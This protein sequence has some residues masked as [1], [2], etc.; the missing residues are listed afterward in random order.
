MKEHNYY[1]ITTYKI[2]ATNY[3]ACVHGRTITIIDLQTKYTFHNI[4]AHHR[5]INK[6]IKYEK[7]TNHI[8]IISRSKDKTIKVWCM[9]D[10]I[11]KYKG[12]TYTCK[13]KVSTNTEEGAIAMYEINEQDFL[14][15]VNDQPKSIQ[16]KNLQKH[17]DIYTLNGHTKEIIALKTYQKNQQPYLA[18]AGDDTTIIIWDLTNRTIQSKLSGHMCAIST[19]EIIR[20]TN[21][22]LYI[23]SGSNDTIKLWDLDTCQAKKTLPVISHTQRIMSIIIKDNFYLFSGHSNGEI[24]LWSE[25]NHRENY[26]PPTQSGCM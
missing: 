3:A 22:K 1:F 26:S 9:K 4:W 11:S 21:N 5:N 12:T 13:Y 6:F 20:N 16:L 2:D 23:A 24:I 8:Y 19:I 18:S 10:L 15:I 14:A 25:N 7:D 17:D